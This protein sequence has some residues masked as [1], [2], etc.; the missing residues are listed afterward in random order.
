MA[1]VH[2]YLAIQEGHWGRGESEKQAKAN[3]KGAGGKGRCSV[4]LVRQHRDASPPYVDMMGCVCHFGKKLEL[5]SGKD[6]LGVAPADEPL[7]RRSRFTSSATTWWTT[8]AP[9]PNPFVEDDNDE[10]NP[11]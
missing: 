4:Y 3:M 5:V 8:T 11:F 10:E 9:A 2:W 7:V 1:L 6:V